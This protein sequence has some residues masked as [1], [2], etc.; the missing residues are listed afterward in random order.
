MA[1]VACAATAGAMLPAFSLAL[2]QFGIQDSESKGYVLTGFFGAMISLIAIVSVIIANCMDL[3]TGFHS[4]AE[5]QRDICSM[6]KGGSNKGKSAQVVIA[7][8]H[9]TQTCL[10]YAQFSF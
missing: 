1:A 4:L 8:A 2:Y 3:W 9:D 6:Q 5:G 10:F 7:F